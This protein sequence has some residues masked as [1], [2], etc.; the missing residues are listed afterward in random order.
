MSQSGVGGGLAGGEVGKLGPHLQR[1]PVQEKTQQQLR[2]VFGGG[3]GPQGQD[4][5]HEDRGL[6]GAERRQV[7]EVIDLHVGPTVHPAEALLQL[8]VGV[9]VVVDQVLHCP[10]GLSWELTYAVVVLR[11][12]GGDVAGGKGRLT[13]ADH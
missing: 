6:L 7:E 1:Q 9:G 12:G 11:D 8:S 13:Y 5:V 3:V 10:Q 2:G 4:V